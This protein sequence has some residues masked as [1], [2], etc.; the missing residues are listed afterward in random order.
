MLLKEIIRMLETIA[1]PSLAEDFDNGRIG[2]VLDRRND[3][4]NIAVAL[5]PT[6]SVLKE[7]ARIGADCS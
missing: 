2:L 1:P 3:I 5:D 6:D 7:A 4:K